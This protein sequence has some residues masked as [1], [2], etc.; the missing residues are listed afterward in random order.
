MERKETVAELR[1]VSQRYGRG[2][3]TLKEVQLQVKRGEF[4]S[5]IGP[6]GA[7]KPH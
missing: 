2:E 3:L 7:G 1:Q 5:V 6:S 4:V